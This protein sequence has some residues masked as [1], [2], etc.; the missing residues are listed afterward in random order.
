MYKATKG[1]SPNIFANTST[2]SNQPN[3]DLGHVTCFKMP[4]VNSAYNGTESI[5]FL[6]PKA[7]KHVLEEVNQKESLNTFKNVMKNCLTTNCP[8]R[9]CKEFL[10]GV[11]FL[12]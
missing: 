2:S 11:G 5:A 12:Q 1:L 3:Y 4:V 10:L 6:D 7:W 8:C 9:L